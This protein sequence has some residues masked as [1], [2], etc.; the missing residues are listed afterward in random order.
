MT[1]DILIINTGVVF[2]KLRKDQDITIEDV[3]TLQVMN[4]GFMPVF[5]NDMELVRKERSTIVVSDGSTSK[6]EL[7]IRFAPTDT[8]GSSEF[9]K[10]SW[11]EKE[12]Y[13]VYKKLIRCRN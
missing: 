12:L 5:I 8:N 11:N 3:T 2:L 1:Q 4:S 10:F 13:I 6:V 7:S 9:S